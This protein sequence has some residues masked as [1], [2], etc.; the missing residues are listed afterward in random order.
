MRKLIITLVS[1]TFA[2]LCSGQTSLVN[3]PIGKMNPINIYEPPAM[4]VVPA[5]IYSMG[6]H[7]ET[8][9]AHELPVHEVYIDAFCMDVFQ[10]TNEEYCFYLNSAYR[11]GE[12]EVKAG[13]NTV[14]KKNDTEPYC[15]TTT[16]SSSSRIEWTGSVFRVTPSDKWNHPVTNLSWYGAVAY[17]NWRSEKSGLPPCYNLETWECSFE[18]GGYRLPTEAEWERAA[19][20]GEHDPYYDFPWGNALDGSKANY[21][22]SGDPYENGTDP[23]TTPV[24]YY[25]GNQIPTGIDMING[26]GLYDMAGNV[27]DWCN[28]WYSEFYY[29]YCIDNDIF[30]NPKGPQVGSCR[31]VRG[32]SW[33]SSPSTPCQLRCS[34]RGLNNLPTLM[35]NRLGFRLVKDY[36][37]QPPMSLVPEGEFEMGDHLGTGYGGESPVHKVYLD[38]FYM[39][40]FQITNEEFCSFLNSAYENYEIEIKGDKVVYKIGDTEPYCDTTE[41]DNASRIEWT[42]YVFQVTPLDKSHHPVTNVSWYGAIA[43]ANWRSQNAGVEPCYDLESWECAFGAGGYRLPTEAEWEK[44]ARGG[45][46]DPYYEFPW[47]DTLDGS[48]ANYLGSGDPYENG[49]E[50]TTTPVGYY[51]GNQIPPGVDMANG[52]GLYDMAGNV[53]DWCNDWYTE[54]YYQYCIDNGIYHNPKG[55][56]SGTCPV[57]RGGSWVSNTTSPCQL[58]CSERG[59]NN[60]PNLMD[61][62]LGFRL[63]RECYEPPKMQT[64]PAGG[65]NMG[66]HH[67][68][69]L[70][71]A[72]P[73]HYVDIDTFYMDTYEVTNLEYCT[74]LNSAFKK[75]MIEVSGG[76]VYKAGTGAGTL[77]C[78][79]TSAPVGPPHWGG[80]SEINWSG[81][82]F[83]VKEG[84][85]DR[86]MLLVSWFGSVAYANWRSAQEGYA[87]CYDLDTWICDFD[88]DGFRLPTEAE[89]EKAS[90]SGEYTPYFR[91]PWGDMIINTI[92]NH[93]VSNDP[94]EVLGFEPFT[95][96]V[97]FYNGEL[98]YKTDFGWPGSALYYQTT[99][100]ENVYGLFDISGNVQEWCNDRYDDTY[101]LYC[102]T[103]GIE[104]NPKGPA[105]GI[106]RVHRGGSWMTNNL[107]VLGCAWRYGD[108]P[109]YVGQA[110]GLRLVRKSP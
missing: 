73:V 55:P 72:V 109:G 5:G 4:T 37:E 15:D 89:W 91:Y 64:I 32:G 71:D 77:Y 8:G 29:Q 20:G 98:H 41:S 28:D 66:D 1:C 88:A 48:K 68:D 94:Y 59:L 27:W 45:E 84:K 54:F 53:W 65:Y 13:N 3:G 51:D 92:V 11:K 38:S 90:R 81:S 80:N 39:D 25:D 74:Y 107:I 97:G 40:I 58:R 95:T 63:V 35:D 44:A 22:G 9:Y 7:F 83:S 69:D 10:V 6:D 78:S 62:R 2:L 12:I 26:Y 47:G 85:E 87:P 19:R 34:E 61:A 75:S 23:T 57:V 70:P 67:E 30:H 33:T 101:Y 42:G 96:P 52:Y 104:D 24:G 50:P 86:P 16:S 100:G 46:H 93:D 105:S 110:L 76:V 106:L 103:Q 17:A 31:V 60:P 21:L 99:D 49:T 14:Y 36:Y 82:A 108:D 79:T 18:L 43:Y 56:E 102:L